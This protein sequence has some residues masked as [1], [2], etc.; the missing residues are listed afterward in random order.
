MKPE[1]MEIGKRYR[2]WHRSDTERRARFSIMDYLGRETTES[3]AGKGGNYLFDAR[4][5]A[6][7]QSMPPHWIRLIEQVSQTATIVLNRMAR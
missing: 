3:H 7:T 4:P 6:G 2:I 1:E 5:L